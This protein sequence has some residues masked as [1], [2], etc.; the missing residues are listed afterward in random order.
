LGTY[1][2]FAYT[3]TFI[4]IMLMMAWLLWRERLGG[5]SAIFA[6]FFLVASTISL[7]F[8]IAL[9]PISLLGLMAIIGVL[10]FTPLFTAVIFFRNAVLALCVSESSFRLSKLI[11]ATLF[12]FLWALAVPFVLQTEVNNSL[13]AV[14]HGSSQTI[15]AEGA[16][17][18]ILSPLVDP[19]KVRDIY[20]TL[21]YYSPERSEVENLYYALTGHAP[22]EYD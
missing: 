16:K 10:G 15:R 18:R 4:S 22:P 6:G 17:L 1:R 8:G 21:P 2:P 5:Y 9:I 3:G 20:F 7:L 13:D 14:A 19:G 12:G 11:P